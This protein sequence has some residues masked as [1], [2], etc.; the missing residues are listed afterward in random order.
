MS[1]NLTE[2]QFRDLGFAV[3]PDGPSRAILTT[4]QDEEEE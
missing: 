3:D 1:I 2:E 4:P